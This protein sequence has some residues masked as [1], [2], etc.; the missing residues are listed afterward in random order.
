[1]KIYILGTCA[2]TEPMEDRHHTSIAIEVDGKVYWFDAGENCS[3]TAHLMGIDLL[4]VSDIFISH[5][6]IDHIGGLENL[7]WNIYKLSNV[8][9]T[10]PRYGDITVHI[11]ND[12]TFGGVLTVLENAET[13]YN[14]KYQT[15]SKRIT[16]SVIM[17]DENVSVEAIHNNHLPKADEGWTSFSFAISAEGKKIVYS[18]DINSFDDILP[19]IK[20]GC[21]VL[22]VETGHH[23]AESVCREIIESGYDVKSVYFI[24]HGRGILYDYDGELEK[25]RKIIPAVTFCNDKDVFTI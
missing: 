20:D 2:G 14:E 9:N 24:H 5:A 4:S 19:F 12:K 1:M 13:G 21:D 6:H 7:L 8:K 15:V 25:C 3:Y 10:L 11:P 22:F 18:G 23:S 16:E 17:T